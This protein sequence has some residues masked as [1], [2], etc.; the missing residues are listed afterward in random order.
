VYFEVFRLRLT[1]RLSLKLGLSL[2]LRPLVFGSSSGLGPGAVFATL[3]FFIT[4]A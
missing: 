3:H 4:Y 2:S 1:L